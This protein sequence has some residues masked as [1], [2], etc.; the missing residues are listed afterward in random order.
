LFHEFWNSYWSLGYYERRFTEA[1]VAV[2]VLLSVVYWRFMLP[3]LGFLVAV[4]LY[5]RWSR[6]KKSL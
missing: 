5:L 4:A 1:G 2:V 6:P 3:F